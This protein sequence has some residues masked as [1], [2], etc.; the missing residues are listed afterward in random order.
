MDALP[1]VPGF[2]RELEAV[3]NTPWQPGVVLEG[4]YELIKLVGA[5]GMGVVWRVFDREW[6]RDLALKMPRPAVL[7]SPIL[8]ER[9]VRE[10]E[11]WIGLGVHPH[12]VQCWFVTEMHGVPA[13]FLD[14]LTGGS[15]KSW[16]DDGHVKP[17]QWDLIIEI[18]MQVAEG[19][20][21]AHSKGVIHRDVKPE[22]L[23]IRGD[24]R[25]CVTD[26]GIVKTVDTREIK[27]KA[28]VAAEENSGMTGVGAYLGT[29]LYGAPEQW[30]AAERVGPSADLYA[31]G[32]TLYEMCCG[33][34]PFDAPGEDPPPEL[35]IQ[36]HLQE[37][38]PD[39]REFYAG[40]P[41]ELARLCLLMLAKN[42]A[43]RPPHMLA[44]REFLSSIYHKL[45]GKS[46]RAPAP[47]LG[48]QSPDVLN[49]Q[50]VSLVNLG[51]LTQAV[52]TL[53]RGLRLDPGHPECLYN[54]VCLEKRHGRIGHLEALRRLKHARAYYPL[55]LLSIEEGMAADAYDLLRS[56]N[57]DDLPSPGLV[58]RATGDALMYLGHYGA[59]ERA[60]AKAHELMSRDAV[61]EQ[62]RRL[63]AEKGRD[64]SGAIHFPSPDPRHINRSSDPSLRLLLDEEGEGLVGLTQS[65]ATYLSLQEGG[66]AAEVA[67]PTSGLDGPQGVRMP[68]GTR[69]APLDP[70][71][72][73]YS[74]LFATSGPHGYPGED[75]SASVRR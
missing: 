51:K 40:V 58:H 41:A 8:R 56:L 75:G 50:A 66:F 14:Y 34:R 49:N 55:A 71:P 9:Y 27:G 68:A 46:F 44:V 37:P 47:L 70:P 21:Y 61:A 39:P 57:P 33:R 35:L 48:A 2:L 12:I 13:L 5:G 62:R 17:G 16:I 4:R 72:G 29:P 30:G 25:V 31:L 26:F 20:A 3:T 19:L 15:L 6:D 59:A 65:T 23:L 64:P 28:G 54:L 73:T 24:E 11:T 69:Y 43:K 74:G 67:R 60:Y 10:A 32:V 63:A 18:A 22:N 7:N 45:T 53:R 36:R 52:E 38:P 1:R 42:P